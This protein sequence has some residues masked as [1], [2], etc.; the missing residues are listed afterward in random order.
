M[1]LGSSVQLE[2]KCGLH[3]EDKI[4]EQL[5]NN[6]TNQ[7]P[8][9]VRAEDSARGGRSRRWPETQRAMGRDALLWRPSQLPSAPAPCFI[10][11]SQQL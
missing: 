4:L 11:L 6:S 7:K 8:L 5:E 1:V 9:F 3:R 2:R 10:R